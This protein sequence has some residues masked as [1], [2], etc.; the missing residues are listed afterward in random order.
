MVIVRDCSDPGCDI[1]V[2]TLSHR[3]TQPASPSAP[4]TTQSPTQSSSSA[5]ATSKAP[6]QAAAAS[7]AQKLVIAIKQN[8]EDFE[9]LSLP[10]NCRKPPQ[11]T[12]ISTTGYGTESPILKAWNRIP[13]LCESWNISPDGKT[14]Q[15][16][17]RKNVKFQSG[18]P[19]TTADVIF[20]L[21]RI[22]ATTGNNLFYNWVANID[23]I[24]VADDYNFTIYFKTPD[25]DFIPW[26][27]IP[28]GSKTYYDRVG[29]QEFVKHPVGTGPYKIV[30][31]QTGQSVTLEAFNDYWGGAPAIKQVQFRYVTEDTTRLAMLKTGEADIITQVPLPMLADIQKTKGLKTL[32]GDPSSGRAIRLK[33]QNLNPKTPWSDIRVRQ[34]MVM[35]INQESIVN[36][37]MYGMVKSW[38]A[39]AP[40]EIGYDATVQNYPYDPAKAKSLLA[41]AG[42]ANGFDMDLNWMDTGLYG[43]KETVAALASYLNAVGIRA[44][45]VQWDAPKWAEYNMSAVGNPDK[46]YALIGAGNFAATPDILTGI[47][48]QYSSMGAITCYFNKDLDALVK[49]GQ[50]T[51]DDNARGELIKKCFQILKDNYVYI[52]LYNTLPIFG[53][54]DNIDYAGGRA[55]GKSYESLCVKDLTSK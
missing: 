36:D 39:C 5:P 44:K 31:A 41:E 37:I 25:E 4:A 53:M 55:V 3:L 17:L 32:T 19:L 2:T 9:I 8:G 49:Q 30:D 7:P 1:C 51:V 22:N 11:S 28:I 38:P 12:Q 24:S 15:C 43:M 45:P 16:T 29:E 52:P 42:Y 21:N 10:H 27:G 26:R 18:D 33:L 54:K 20:S 14:L 6:T 50:A 48:D 47:H 13:G 35:A 40:G 23:H 46:D 34:A